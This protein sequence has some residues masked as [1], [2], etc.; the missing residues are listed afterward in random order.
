[1]VNFWPYDLFRAFLGNHSD[2]M[3]PERLVVDGSLTAPV[4]Q[5]SADKAVLPVSSPWHMCQSMWD[6]LPIPCLVFFSINENLSLPKGLSTP[7]SL[8]FLNCTGEIRMGCDLTVNGDL[9]VVGCPK[10]SISKGTTINGA[11]VEEPANPVFIALH[12]LAEAKGLIPQP[13]HVAAYPS[14]TE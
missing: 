3:L 5:V 1:M 8:F 2:A 7:G 4:H 13:P 14:S 10:F 6:L 9:V 11:F 12:A